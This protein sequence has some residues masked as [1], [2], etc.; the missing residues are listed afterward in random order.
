MQDHRSV[1][2]AKFILWCMSISFY[3][4]ALI[5]VPLQSVWDGFLLAGAGVYFNLDY[6]WRLRPTFYYLYNEPILLKQMSWGLSLV[7]L[8]VAAVAFLRNDDAVGALCLVCG[9]GINPEIRRRM[10]FQ[11]VW[12]KQ[13]EKAEATKVKNKS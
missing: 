8:A 10:R 7:V 11:F 9:L 12:A 1:V 3:V 13:D 5:S 4:A 6:R 2:Q